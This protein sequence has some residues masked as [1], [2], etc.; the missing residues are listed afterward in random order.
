MEIKKES[1]EPHLFI[2]H[3]LSLYPIENIHIL[4]T[5]ITQKIPPAIQT[6]IHDYFHQIFTAYPWIHF[7]GGM[8]RELAPWIFLHWIVEYPSERAYGIMFFLTYVCVFFYILLT[9]TSY[10]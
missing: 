4:T 3:I 1:K 7:D 10:D 6:L 2:E 5:Q 8:P 9:F